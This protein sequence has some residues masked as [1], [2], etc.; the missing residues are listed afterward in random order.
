MSGDTNSTHTKYMHRCIQ[1]AQMGEGHVSPNPLVGCVIVHNDKIIGEG[2]HR[3]YGGPHAEVHAIASVKNP[4]LLP[5]ST[6]YVSL[7]PCAH[8]GKTPPCALLIIEKRIKHVVIGC[9]DPFPMVNGKGVELLKNAGIT[10]TLGVLEQECMA[11]NRRFFTYH[12]KQRPYIILK[13]A[14]SADGYID[15]DRAAGN[16]LPTWIT[17][18]QC[19]TLVHK[20]RA[21]EDAVMIGTNTAMLDNPSLT[22]REWAGKNPVRIVLDRNL[23]LPQNL[24]IFDE[25]STN[26]IFTEKTG[27]NQGP[28]QYITIDFSHDI[29]PQILTALHRQN[30]ISVVVEGGTQ[31][32]QTFIDGG[33]Y[34][35]IYRYIGNVLF[36]GGTKA[37]Q[38]AVQPKTETTIGEVKLLRY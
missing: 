28:T 15:K 38:L 6:I 13:W 35:E 18:A 37:P 32:L 30:I 11:L 33:Y 9:R 16:Q 23:R 7:E 34:D 4:E 5:E 31:L 3:Q 26:I 2:Y 24:T 21:A 1:L 27:L 12:Q 17:N 8:Y 36:K 25:Q 14:E 29:I 10:V 19:R 22:V 20:Q